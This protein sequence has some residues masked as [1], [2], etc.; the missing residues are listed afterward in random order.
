MLNTPGG[1]PAASMHSARI[2]ASIGGSGDG[3]LRAE[4]RPG[5]IIERTARGRD[6]AI[7]VLGRRLGVAQQHFLG[8]RRN[9]LELLAAGA[10]DKLS[11]DEQAGLAAAGD[12][13]DRAGEMLH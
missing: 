8:M 13:A 5:P 1:S 6:G 12:A 11:I 2:W 4:A 10:L 9:D 7:D 3:F